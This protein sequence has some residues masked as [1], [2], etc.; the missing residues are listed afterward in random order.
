MK[1]RAIL[2]IVGILVF[3]SVIFAY[4]PTEVTKSKNSV[5]VVIPEH[6]VQVADNVFSLGNSIDT[7]GNVVEGYLFITN[8]KENAH[9]Q[10]SSC[11]AFISKGARWKTTEQYIIDSNLDSALTESSLEAWDSQ[12]SFDV[13]G[14]RNVNGIIDG[15]DSSGPD[16]K[17]EVLFNNL[18]ATSTV[19]Y[20]II[21]GVLS[22]P[23][24]Q[25]KITEWDT[26]FNSG[27]SWS[28]TGE[29]GKMD[30]MNVAVHEFGHSIGM[31]HPSD[32]CTDESM[33]RFVDYGETK[34]RSLNNGDIVGIKKLYT[35]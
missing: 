35:G 19:A 21:W 25:R 32:S 26:V 31:A 2:S 12:V 15:A 27:Y 34:K 8:K 20:T 29:A 5:H 30:Y 17:N 23:L 9:I 3:A 13:V 7:D 16:G 22:G 11:Y 14:T 10:T 4:V 33:Y 24:N 28:L 18:G 6:A 1:Y